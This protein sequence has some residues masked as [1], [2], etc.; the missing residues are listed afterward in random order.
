MPFAAWR[1]V[2]RRTW[3][4]T[5]KDNIGL[6]A[7]GVAFYG[8]LALIPLLG[9]TVL[10]YGI[11]ADPPTVM[12]DMTK[13]TSVMPADVAKLIGE[14]LMNVVKTSD[15]K[16]GLGLLI[17]LALALFGARNGAGAVITALNVA[18]EEQETRSFIHVN[19]LALT[20]TTAAVIVAMLALAAITALGYLEALIPNAP[21]TLIAIGKIAVYALLMLAGAAGAATL[22]RYGP[23]RRRA[24]WIWLTPGSLFAAVM[25]LALT[26][27]F[28]I[29][30]ANFGN[31]NAT[32]GSLGTV[33]IT[34][35]WLY[36]SSYILLFGAEL[37]A[38]LE[39]QTA[40]DTTNA[41]APIGERGAWVA[42]HV[43]EDTHTADDAI[44]PQPVG[45]TAPNSSSMPS[46]IVASR[47]V[48]RAGGFAGLPKG[49]LA[50]TVAANLGLSL[51]RRGRGWPG[52]ALLGGT[53]ALVWLRRDRSR[54][55]IMIKAIF[56]DVDGTLVDSN[57]QHVTA[58]H[59]AFADQGFRVDREAIRGQIGKGG[60]L[61]VPALVP[62][63]SEDM[64]KRLS[65]RHGVLF[66][67]AHLDTV[68]PFPAATALIRRVHESGRKV[69]LASSADAKEVG[70]Y[71][72]QLGIRN[73]LHA[74][75]TI[76]DAETSKPAGDIF[77][78]ALAK[79][80]PLTPDE[81]IV[82]GDTP[83]DV[84]AASKCGIRT[85]AVRSGGFADDVLL[86]A[87]AVA[88]YDDVAALLARFDESPLSQ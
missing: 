19:L 58:W 35:T 50:A 87:G 25:W 63:A 85:V 54:E 13:L 49:G 72:E 46:A 76:D 65:K 48:A 26:V 45:V 55:H 79:V 21:E 30:V 71:I 11:V 3:A 39:H 83:Y 17:A 74:M 81:V 37:N 42:D 53:A 20:I 67:R 16:K 51:L 6:I 80:K 10:V 84:E 18:Y 1:A 29:Y 4:E 52:L 15:G 40:R 33:V 62:D 44:P 66:K 77:A 9:A 22:Y 2:A 73:A 32:Y 24:R 36:L 41:D 56:F 23:S 34:L 69:V 31:Y 5:G 47:I 14:Q 75:T 60:D 64:R 27:G 88:L 28:G 59:D 61:L 68:K 43:A 12:R 7:A 78:A 82:V 38:E 8:F 70:H 86:D 57:E